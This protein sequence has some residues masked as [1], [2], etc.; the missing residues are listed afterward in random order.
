MMVMDCVCYDCVVVVVC[1]CDV[2]CGVVLMCGFLKI[3]IVCAV[4]NSN[5][6]GYI[7]CVV[8]CLLEW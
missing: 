7:L 6:Y 2:V 3:V 1:F 4:E 8:M 5:G